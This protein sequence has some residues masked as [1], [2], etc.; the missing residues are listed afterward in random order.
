MKTNAR[1][2]IV[3]PAQT[4]LS[5]VLIAEMLILLAVASIA[6]SWGAIQVPWGDVW[7]IVVR[8][9][10]SLALPASID[11]THA[12]IIWTLRAPR[13]ALA[14]LVGAGLSLAGVAAQALVRNPLADP[15]VLGVSSGAS[16]MAVA[17]ILFGLGS[18]G[19]A[20]TSSA[21]FVGSIAA[22]ILVII[23]G[24]R[25]GVIA[26]MRL[27]LAGVAIGHLL[28]G[29]TSFLVLRATDAHQVFGV[30]FWLQGSLARSDWQFLFMPVTAILVGGAILFTDA[31]KL[32]AL[33]VGDETAASLGVNVSALRA[34]LLLL[35]SLLTAVMVSL[36]GIIGFVGLVVPHIARMLVGSDHRRV[37]PV[38]ALAGA[39]FL[40]L[41][42]AIARLL[43][44]PTEIPVGII[45]GIF[46]APFFLWLLWRADNL[47]RV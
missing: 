13:A 32:N 16:V 11:P 1:T 35:T 42:D 20:S 17:A 33:L 40:V 25:G 47:A 21:A 26:P 23:F 41:C 8:R 24:Q 22:M 5:M 39:I 38:A 6:I 27:I 30:L 37:V 3:T 44:A 7:L 45:T 10:V 46:G 34:R 12:D 15:Y 29:V 43:I 28:A 2:V 18:F 9:T 14:T 31:Q 19:L 4:P 36:S